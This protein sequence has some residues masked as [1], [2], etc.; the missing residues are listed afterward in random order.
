[1]VDFIFVDLGYLPFHSP[2]YKLPIHVPEPFFL[3]HFLPLLLGS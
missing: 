1:M 3:A 2:F